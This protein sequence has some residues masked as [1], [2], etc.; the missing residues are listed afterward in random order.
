[1]KF[2]KAFFESMQIN[3]AKSKPIRA[4][5]FAFSNF[6]IITGRNTACLTLISLTLIREFIIEKLINFVYVFFLNY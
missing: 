5:Q 3:P 2:L 4:A 1:M 6:R